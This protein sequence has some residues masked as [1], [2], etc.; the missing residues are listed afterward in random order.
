MENL[1]S[2]LSDLEVKIEKYPLAVSPRL[3]D[4]FLI[5]GYT[6]KIKQ[7]K[8][9]NI[10]KSDILSKNNFKDIDKIKEHTINHLP[11]VLSS[12]TSNNNFSLID[13]QTF[14]K[15]VFPIPPKIFYTNPYKYTSEPEISRIVFNNIQ[16]EAVNIGYAYCFYEKENI[17]LNEKENLIIYFPKAFVIISQYNY[18]YTFHKI[19]ENLHRQYLSDNIEIPLEIQIY[20]IVNFLPCPLDNKIELSIFPYIDLC[21]IIKCKNKEEFINMNKTKELFIL[22]QLG[23]YKHTE[24]NFCKI[25]DFFSPGNLIQIY[26]QLLCGNKIAFFSDNKELLNYTILVFYHLFFPLAGSENVL[27]LNP[28]IYFINDEILHENILG[29]ATSYLI[30]E[31]SDPMPKDSKMNFLVF[32]DEKAADR[33]D[34]GKLKQ[35]C[36]FIVDIDGGNLILYEEPKIIKN[37]NNDKENGEE[38]DDDNDSANIEDEVNEEDLKRNKF[39]FAYFNSLFNDNAEGN[40]GIV[41]NT[42]IRELYTRLKSLSILIK[43]ENLTSFFIENKEIKNIS[44]QIQEAF[45]RFNL[46][47]CD[48]Y[49]NIFSLYK[50]GLI[51]EQDRNRKKREELSIS[52]AE[53]YFYQS[54]EQTPNRDMLINLICGYDVGEPIIYKA[55]KRGFDNLLAS[56][57]EDSNNIL[58]LKDHYIELLDCVF[59]NENENNI[60]NISFFEFF[61]FFNDN[62][63]SY[64]Y[65][66][67]NDDYIDKNV[68]KKDNTDNYYYKYKKIIIDKDLLLKYC[69]YLDELSEE[70]KKKIFPIEENESSIE[71]IIYSKDFYKAYDTFLV[72]HKIY[73]V[74]N[75]IQFCILNIVILSTSELKLISFEEPIYSLIKS[76]NLGIRKYVELILNV[77]YRVLIKKNVTN[78]NIAKKYFDIY[79]ICIEE[80]KIFPNDELI[81]IEKNISKYFE[82]LKEEDVDTPNEIVNK[83]QNTEE[84]ALFKFI[85]ENEDKNEIGNEI[86]ENLQKEGKITKNISLK[87][88]LL[89]KEE[90]K[91]DFIYY[92]YSLYLKLNEL[93]D[94]YYISLD[95]ESFDKDEYYKLIINV[96]YYVRHI[97]D[98]IP[99]GILKFLF[100]CLCK[101]KNV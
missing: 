65:K 5:M 9:I 61:K 56:C 82:L 10:I 23:G 12:I 30:L 51:K 54:F 14:I 85:P 21:S 46:L 6:D 24:I 25:L 92:P 36:E 79:K 60:K 62:L 70:T 58:I 81:I 98:K 31:F 68:V 80:K 93:V 39:L 78:I 18:F 72:S 35:K 52:E 77:S 67:I 83:I 3:L 38:N 42:L 86:V 16:N 74:K 66:N 26:L 71:K 37:N 7:E 99:Q 48:N 32:E 63:K 75:I 34:F 11:T 91:N 20:N 4:E 15:Y 96:I 73:L 1:K 100:Y 59:R 76:M 94:K 33:K 55:S 47:I 45:L 97:K 44:E 101:T 27:S 69:Y 2:E 19:C 49:F 87:S 41:L 53:F 57:K 84:N 88:D 95:F 29:F 22:E 90:I 40:L 13:S 17:M 89:N 43:N 64:I 50:G 8:A 28:N